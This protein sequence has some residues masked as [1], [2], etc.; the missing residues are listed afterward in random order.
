MHHPPVVLV[1]HG[2]RDPRAAAATWALARAVAAARPGLDVHASFLDH[3][4]PRPG[5]ILAALDAAGHDR[6]VLAPLLLTAA[7]HSRVDVPRVVTAARAEGVRLAVGVADVLGPLDVSVDPA[8]I[9]G[10]T[11][12]LSEAAADYEAVVLV[13]AG[14]RHAG[15]RATVGRVAAA[16]GASLDV[17]CTV[18]WASA[19]RP[20][21]AAAVR[22]LRA[23]GARRVGVASYFLA[24]GFLHDRAVAAALEAGAAVVSAPLLDSA[25][26][27]SV[28]LDR[29]DGVCRTAGAIAHAA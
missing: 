25:D 16:L 20:G 21:P 14:T 18:G 3:A 5:E 9:A 24:P 19:A 2:S 11:A 7:F 27:V 17:P 10:L 26:L 15:A 12:R 28:V 6:V 4:G 13:A 8:L 29:L 22:R 23:A 1:A